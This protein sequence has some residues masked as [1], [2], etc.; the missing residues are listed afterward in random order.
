MAEKIVLI[1]E[2]ANTW[3][4]SFYEAIGF[5]RSAFMHPDYSPDEFTG[6]EYSE[7]IPPVNQN[8]SFKKQ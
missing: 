4:Q 6:F 1:T 2:I 7:I 3:S 8:S 5:K